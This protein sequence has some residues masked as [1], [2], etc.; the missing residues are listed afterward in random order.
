MNCELKGYT[1]QVH[2]MHISNNSYIKPHI[3]VSDLEASFISWFVKGDPNGK[4][5]GMF[6]HCLKFDNNHGAGIF[7]R[8]KFVTHETL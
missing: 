7:V 1:T 2:Q 6:Q 3:D 4:Y 5:F 8:S